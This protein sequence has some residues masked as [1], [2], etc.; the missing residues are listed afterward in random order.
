MPVVARKGKKFT[1]FQSGL[2]KGGGEVLQHQEY[3]EVRLWFLDACHQ[4]VSL[5]HLEHHEILETGAWGG[6]GV[7]KDHKNDR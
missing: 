3:A 5:H 4:Q 2:G 6:P 1:I 7:A